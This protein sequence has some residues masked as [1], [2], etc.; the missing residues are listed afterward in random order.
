MKRILVILLPIFA[1]AACEEKAKTVDDWMK[2]PDEARN[3]AAECENK[4]G[5]ALQKIPLSCSTAYEAK[6]KI[7][8]DDMRKA[9]LKND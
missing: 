3:F 6:R 5:V 4:Y 1:L 9:R 7:L 2:T 8:V